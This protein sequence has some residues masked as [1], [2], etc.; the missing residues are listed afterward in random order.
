M[1]NHRSHTD[2]GDLAA[3]ESLSTIA[4]TLS[5]PASGDRAFYHHWKVYRKRRDSRLPADL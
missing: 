2:A 1:E 3:T 4:T 5:D